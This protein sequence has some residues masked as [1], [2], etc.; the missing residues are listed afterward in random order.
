MKKGKEKS[1]RKGRI[2]IGGVSDQIM[3][4]TLSEVF[5]FLNRIGQRREQKGLLICQ[6]YVKRAQMY[7]ILEDKRKKLDHL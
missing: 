3:E 2:K 4:L 7:A 1:S 5:K 6:E